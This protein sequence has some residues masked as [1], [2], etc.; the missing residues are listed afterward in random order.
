MKDTATFCSCYLVAMSWWLIAKKQRLV[1]L[2]AGG[3]LC[4]S[5]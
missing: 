2:P 5:T 1:L 4:L 3:F